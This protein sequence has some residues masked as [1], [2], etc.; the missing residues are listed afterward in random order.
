MTQ[1]NTKKIPIDA[2]TETFAKD[3]TAGG[4]SSQNGWQPG[5][6]TPYASSLA[7]V[8]VPV[9]FDYLLEN[10]PPFQG[11]KEAAHEQRQHITAAL[12]KE[13][14]TTVAGHISTTLIHDLDEE[15]MAAIFRTI[16]DSLIFEHR[17]FDSGQQNRTIFLVQNYNPEQQTCE[18]IG[19][20]NIEFR[21]ASM[22]Y[23]PQTGE[24]A[25]TTL[26]ITIRTSL[27]TDI[28]ELAAEVKFLKEH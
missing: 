22:N 23:I 9:H 10:Y 15:H 26:D 14:F 4:Y 5:E 28:D 27:Y 18:G 11:K 3:F 1:K 16:I 13:L 6:P 24:Y 8:A 19:F 7:T 25:D 2:L 12:W 17:A 20:I 21:L